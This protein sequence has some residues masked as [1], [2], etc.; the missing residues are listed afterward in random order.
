MPS[1][2]NP[3]QTETFP[4]KMLHHCY[5]HVIKCG[6]GDD[7]DEGRGKNKMGRCCLR[8]T[9]SRVAVTAPAKTK[10]HENGVYH[11]W[12]NTILF[13]ACS[14]TPSAGRNPSCLHEL[15]VQLHH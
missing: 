15:P 12:E 6:G 5:I 10:V 8:F 14:G 11:I 4:F 3:K 7:D 13:L 2:K 1:I 9:G